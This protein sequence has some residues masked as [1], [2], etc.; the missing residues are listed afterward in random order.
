MHAVRKWLHLA[1]VWR[2]NASKFKR[3]I[4]ISALLVLSG[5]ACWSKPS[6]IG[7]YQ[8][9]V[10]HPRAVSIYKPVA[11][12]P[13]SDDRLFLYLA[14]QN[15]GRPEAPLCFACWSEDSKRWQWTPFKDL[16]PVI[17]VVSEDA[18]II[19]TPEVR[20]AGVSGKTITPGGRFPEIIP[21]P[22][23]FPYNEANYSRDFAIVI[24]PDRSQIGATGYLAVTVSVA[25]RDQPESGDGLAQ[26]ASFRI[27]VTVVDQFRPEAMTPEPSEPPL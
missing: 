18:P 13:P 23:D 7:E 20:M 11:G 27:P 8:F 1:L 10:L 4:A 17:S 22:T 9:S 25:R 2:Q 16:V 3:Q 5:C 14:L 6:S 15:D 19:G 24:H 21:D 26:I 12:L